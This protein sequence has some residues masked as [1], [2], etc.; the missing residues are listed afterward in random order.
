[1]IKIIHL[2][3]NSI[4]EGSIDK[5][6]IKSDETWVDCLSPT[7][8]ELK[9]IAEQTPVSIVDFDRALDEYERPSVLEFD[10][11]SV[12]T[13]HAPFVNRTN[14]S[15]STVPVS[16]FVF[17]HKILILRKQELESLSRIYALDESKKINIMKKDMTIS[18][19][20]YAIMSE[21]IN[22]FFTY[23]D[24]IE[25]RIEKLEENV[26]KNPNKKTVKE[27]FS[28]KKTMIY[29]HKSLTGN[30]EVI[31]GIEKEFVKQV[32]G[33]NLQ[34]FRY[35][36][37]DITQ[38]IDMVGTYRDI[39]TGSLDIY[40]TSVSNNLNHVMK[41][42][43]VITSFAMFPTLIASIYGMNFRN[44]PELLWKWGYPFSFGLMFLSVIVMYIYF[45]K[46][47]WM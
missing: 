24:E 11:F 38:L 8:E 19:S 44:M 6:K 46:M 7:R 36:Y 26:F 18:Y 35:L 3:Q 20:L 5:I 41:K 40:L 45:K 43:T 9:K 13:F 2:V 22:D 21:I 16:F 29:F 34:K 37:N 28:L 15:L 30:R 47:D 1:M 23:I 14:N 39:L 25:G 27:I 10:E 4:K 42:L 31:T 17:N 32:K 33:K 12:I